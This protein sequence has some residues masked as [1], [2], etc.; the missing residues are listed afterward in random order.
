MNFETIDLPLVVIIWCGRVLHS[1]TRTRTGDS[2]QKEVPEI[3]PNKYASQL[4][5]KGSHLPVNLSHP[6]Y[7]F[8]HSTLNQ[9][10][11]T[12]VIRSDN[13][14]IEQLT[15]TEHG[16]VPYTHTNEERLVWHRALTVHVDVLVVPLTLH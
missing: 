1:P 13:C 8:I 12:E 15:A 6:I 4:Q 11:Q 3:H 7:I 2:E 16:Y 10:T 5:V 9:L 14:G